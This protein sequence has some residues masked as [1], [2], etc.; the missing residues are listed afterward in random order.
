MLWS[1]RWKVQVRTIDE[2]KRVEA[3]MGV[4]YIELVH[5]YIQDATQGQHGF[6]GR[7]CEK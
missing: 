2:Q 5:A 7:M 3:V 4:P 1:K 6:F